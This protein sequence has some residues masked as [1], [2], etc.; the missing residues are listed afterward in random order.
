MKDKRITILLG[1]GA[2][3]PFIE[4]DNKFLTTKYLTESLCNSNLWE[5]V[6]SD[7]KRYK[8]E[9][10]NMAVWA[11][12]KEDVFFVIDRIIKRLEVKNDINFE[13][14]LY[15]LDHIAP[16]LHSKYDW[17]SSMLVDFWSENNNVQS[18]AFQKGSDRQGWKYAPF[19]AREVLIRAVLNLWDPEKA[20]TKDFVDQ[21]I[22]FYKKIDEGSI[23]LSIYSLNY[24]PLI[25]EV[26][27]GIGS[28]TMAF[29]GNNI[30]FQNDVFLKDEN[31]V[32]S[33]LHGHVGFVPIG[34]Q[35][36]FFNEDYQEAQE[37]RLRGIFRNDTQETRFFGFGMRGLHYNTYIVSGFDKIDAF[38][39]NPFSCY[40]HRFSRD[41]LEADYIVVIGTSLSDEHLNLFFKN[42]LAYSNKKIIF[43]GKKT[44]K[45]EWRISEDLEFQK[46][47]S[48]M[49]YISG[50]KLA[51]PLDS[52]EKT[53]PKHFENINR[54]LVNN[55]YG[56]ITNNVF[57]YAKGVEEFYRVDDME[58][59]LEEIREK[60]VEKN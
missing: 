12:E 57:M 4:K 54:N 2:S 34:G 59:L 9:S 28:I 32:I 58:A 60:Q 6:L 17:P 15:F 31:K 7:F 50:D 49:W 18:L 37:I 27:K 8:I 10:K 48:R 47:M 44:I 25:A 3:A 11:L 38:Y 46:E 52:M 33:F 45:Q 14:I 13:S 29:S 55:G 24:D 1:A 42:S 30:G 20:T 36:V 23:R 22:K 26:A 56:H 35:Q 53:L 16:N 51:L 39:S 43:V 5:S 21:N 19:L 41:M 40:M